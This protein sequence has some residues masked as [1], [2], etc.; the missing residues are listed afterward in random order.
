MGHR[1]LEHFRVFRTRIICFEIIPQGIFHLI[2]SIL[3]SIKMNKMSF[4]THP[5]IKENHLIKNKQVPK[6]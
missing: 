6:K 3:L 2:L 1:A 5:S 4:I